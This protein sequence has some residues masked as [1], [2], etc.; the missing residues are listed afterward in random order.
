MDSIKQ[1]RQTLACN[2]ADYASRFSRVSLLL[3]LFLSLAPR[4]ISGAFPEFV[5]GTPKSWFLAA[6]VTVARALAPAS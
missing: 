5:I 6:R 4:A 2:T 3:L 1:S